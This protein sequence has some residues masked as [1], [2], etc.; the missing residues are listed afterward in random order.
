MHEL[1]QYRFGQLTLHI[2]LYTMYINIYIY[3][4]KL[5][6]NLHMLK[7]I[8]TKMSILYSMIADSNI[9]ITL[10]LKKEKTQQYHI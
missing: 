10:L 5:A 1:L 4:D 7:F 6:F 3:I 2:H 8:H 9:N